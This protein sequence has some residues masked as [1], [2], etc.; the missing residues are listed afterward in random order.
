M[1]GVNPGIT[2]WGAEEKADYSEV[3]TPHKCFTCRDRG[4]IVVGEHPNG[5]SDGIC[6]DCKRGK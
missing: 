1:P 5:E 4:I 2:T 3:R 6:P